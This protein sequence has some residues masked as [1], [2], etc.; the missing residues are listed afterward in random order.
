M[1]NVIEVAKQFVPVLD[2]VYKQSSVTAVLDGNPELVQEGA[3]AGELII[4]MLDMQGL[5]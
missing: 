3:N 4:P 5:C 1:P 2:A